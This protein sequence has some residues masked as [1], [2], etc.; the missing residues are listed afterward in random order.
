MHLH[1][2]SWKAYIHINTCCCLLCFKRRSLCLRGMITKIGKFRSHIHII[3]KNT[4]LFLL[5]ISSSTK[6]LFFLTKLSGNTTQ[7]FGPGGI[8]AIPT[9]KPF[10]GT[11][12]CFECASTFNIFKQKYHCRNCGKYNI[13]QISFPRSSTI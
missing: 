10:N 11:K 13:K 5:F 12:N 1:Q 6:T 9:L 8:F 7:H 4:F 3:I 2:N